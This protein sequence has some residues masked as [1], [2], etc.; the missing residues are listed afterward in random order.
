M[1][2][3]QIYFLYFGVLLAS[4]PF[5]VEKAESKYSGYWFAIYMVAAILPPVIYGLCI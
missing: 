4:I 5:I 3:A 2:I 1:N